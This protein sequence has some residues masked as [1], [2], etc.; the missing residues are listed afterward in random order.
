M[1]IGVIISHFNQEED[2]SRCLTSLSLQTYKPAAVIVVDD[3]SQKKVCKGTLEGYVSNLLL[4]HT[5]RPSGGPA[6]PRNEGII[7]NPCEYSVFVDADDSLLPH[8]LES[9]RGI[10]EKNPN[11]I[12]C[13]DMIAW[14]E[15]GKGGRIQKSKLF[16]IRTGSP[17]QDL[18]D[19]L[20][21]RGN[22]IVF[23]GSGGPTSTFKR[24]LFDPNQRWE[25]FDLWLRLA[26]N[27]HQFHHTGQIHTLYQ[28]KENSRS[29]SAHARRQ[30]CDDIR[31]EHYQGRKTWQMP[32]WWHKQR[33]T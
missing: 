19:Q 11:A 6:I 18:Y 24:Y 4:V 25:D 12:G 20:R 32:M 16:D 15:S 29:G 1:D 5:K 33:W 9:L 27:G 3:C 8:T 21:L 7:R 2:L 13:G 14:K 31:K 26:K 23:S 30:G 28:L 10:W 17:S 22:D